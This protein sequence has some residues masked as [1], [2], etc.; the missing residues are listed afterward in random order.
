MV[1]SWMRRKRSD[2]DR[3][4]RTSRQGLVARRPMVDEPLERRVVPATIPI[5][6]TGV[7]SDGTL[8]PGGQ[9]DPHFTLVSAPIP[10][11]SAYVVS[12]VPP[13]YVANTSSSQWIAPSADAYGVQNIGNYDYRETFN[14]G[15]LDPA[16]AALQIQIASDNESQILLNGVSAGVVLAGDF[17]SSSFSTLH[18]LTISQGF[19]PGLNTLDVVVTNEGSATGLQV[20]VT[21]TA[22]A[23]DVA[24]VRLTSAFEGTG[25]TAVNGS[26][27]GVPSTTY[28][29]NFYQSPPTTP[30]SPSVIGSTT[31]T[32]DAAGAAAIAINLPVAVDLGQF[33]L[34][35]ATGPSGTSSTL[36]Q[37][38]AVSGISDLSVSVAGLASS[39]IVGQPAFVVVTV[40]N[41]GPSP[42][43]VTLGN[44]LSSGVMLLS[45]TSTAGTISFSGPI[46][47]VSIPR[48]DAGGSAVL[49]LAVES[50]TPGTVSDA[51]EAMGVATDPNPA[52][53][54]ASAVGAV[55]PPPSVGPTVVAIRRIGDT[56]KG[57]QFVLGFDESLD[58]S[59][60]QN[61]ANYT[62]IEPGPDGRF[63]TRDDR[64]QVLVSAAYNASTRTVVLTTRLKLPKNQR[65]ELI[66][67]GAG[68]QGIANSSGQPL[69]T[70][71]SGISTG[72][73]R[74]ILRG[75]KVVQQS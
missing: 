66:A 13:V 30:V 54:I 74:A 61:R 40:T 35:T 73:F 69:N 17:S 50:A 53:N 71:P 47:N 63:G 20:Q 18:P 42:T 57:S 32:T 56:R 27:Q 45:E 24:T 36:S 3:Q 41:H 68:P 33:L 49:T 64:P 60:A 70:G 10:A 43:P 39:V 23:A 15:G 34:A 37:P 6:S 4:G 5:Y 7:L 19:R 2:A 46:L 1:R 28:H 26:V 16:S 52:D 48:L 67:S 21:G 59:S 65:L 31:V 12:Q 14:L 51:A 75:S 72:P 22:N 25:I 62:L 29:V 58:V 8:L 44:V 11:T 9:V 38:L 55:V